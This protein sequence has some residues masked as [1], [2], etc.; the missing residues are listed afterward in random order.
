MPDREDGLTEQA[1][2][3]AREE[4]KVDIVSMSFGY[5]PSPLQ[6]QSQV[7]REIELCKQAGPL[8]F[9]A[10]SNDGGNT[11][12]TFPATCDGVIPVYATDGCGNAY[13][14]NPKGGND[15]IKFAP[16]RNTQR[17]TQLMQPGLLIIS[18]DVLRC[19]GRHARS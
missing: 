18:H 14:R 16:K 7:I 17:F 4:W 13:E 11:S 9:A 12:P 2:K 15:N 6:P 5:R 1:I 8:L 10:A 19:A 3:Y